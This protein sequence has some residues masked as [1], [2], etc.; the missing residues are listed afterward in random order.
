MF[1]PQNNQDSNIQPGGQQQPTQQ[2]QSP[3]EVPIGYSSATAP[4][5]PDD[6]PPPY[7]GIA[8]APTGYPPQQIGYS[9]QSAAYPAVPPYPDNPPPYP[10]PP[11]EQAQTQQN[12]PPLQTKDSYD[13]Q[14]AFNPNM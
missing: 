6:P 2:L 13:R 3:I 4:P 5:Y 7:P 12:A 8:Q 1:I 11:L 14:P 9:S 10:G